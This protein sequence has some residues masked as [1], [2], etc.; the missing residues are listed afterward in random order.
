M[1]KGK[2]SKGLT[3]IALIITIVVLLIIAIVIINS[4]KDSNIVKYA[5]KARTEY[6]RG[7]QEEKSILAQ[8]EKKLE[9][10]NNSDEIKT[11]N[12][13]L[14]LVE[15]TTIVGY[16]GKGEQ[17]HNVTIPSKVTIDG[18]EI[19]IKTIGTKNLKL[20]VE[21]GDGDVDVDNSKPMADFTGTLII[22]EGIETIEDLAFVNSQITQVELPEGITIGMGGFVYSSLESV[23]IPNNV[24]LGTVSFAGTKIED[25]VFEGEAIFAGESVFAESNSLLNITISGTVTEIGECAFIDCQNLKTLVI[26]EGVEKIKNDAFE[27]CYKLENV[28][29]PNSLITIE[30]S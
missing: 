19:Q 17:L 13:G 3:L 2:E 24:K 16:K 8:Y 21:G 23:N 20:V 11:D 6:E 29:L 18:K 28:T 22:E 4:I 5:E 25:I 30:K 7:K 26:Q 1:N 9:N 14:W 27:Y 12:D 10:A 15:G